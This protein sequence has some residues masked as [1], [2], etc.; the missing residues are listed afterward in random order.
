MRMYQPIW[1]RLKA[2]KF[3]Q[4]ACSPTAHKRIRKAVFKER[5]LDLAYKFESEGKREML[6]VWSEGTKLN[7]KLTFMP[8]SETQLANL[9][10]KAL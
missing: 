7:F 9:S 4:I 8:Y 5:G 1:E 10:A 2:D 3:V 6:E